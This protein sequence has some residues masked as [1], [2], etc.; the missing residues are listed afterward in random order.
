MRVRMPRVRRFVPAAATSRPT[1]TPRTR[2]GSGTVAAVPE[3]PTDAARSKSVWSRL[4]AVRTWFGAAYDWSA[5]GFG[6]RAGAF[7]VRY[8]LTA[9]S[10]AR[11]MSPAAVV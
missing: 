4:W 1:T 10:I 7:A 5:L 11:W 8:D 9:A 3:L 2:I 6:A